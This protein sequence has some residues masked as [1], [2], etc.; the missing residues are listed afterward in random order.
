[1]SKSMKITIH[2]GRYGSKY[3]TFDN[4]KVQVKYSIF[5]PL[6]EAVRYEENYDEPFYKHDGPKW[7]GNCLTHGSCHGV[8]IA[9]CANCVGYRN[10]PGC[11]CTIV[12]ASRDKADWVPCDGDDCIFKTY[13]KNADFYKIGDENEDIEEKYLAQTYGFGHDEHEYLN[14]EKEVYIPMYAR[15]ALNK[16]R[17]VDNEAV[18]FDRYKTVEMQTSPEKVNKKILEYEEQDRLDKEE[19][20]KWSIKYNKLQDFNHEEEERKKS[21]EEHVKKYMDVFKKGYEWR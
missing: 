7:C 1:M 8:F 21:E 20:D 18:L 13:L 3:Y 14:L 19:H 11:A 9:Y 10:L 4:A 2:E 12:N 17:M 6:E 16:Y 15:M 5:F